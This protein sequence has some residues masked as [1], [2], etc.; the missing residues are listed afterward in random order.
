MGYQYSSFNVYGNVN[1]CSAGSHWW[2][3]YNDWGHILRTRISNY[4]MVWLGRYA[5]PGGLEGYKQGFMAQY[6]NIASD[7]WNIPPS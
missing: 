4:Y 2:P 5:E 1:S 6:N 3:S 7:P